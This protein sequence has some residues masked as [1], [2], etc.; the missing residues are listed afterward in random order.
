LKTDVSGVNVATAGN[1]VVIQG[2]RITTSGTQTYNEAVLLNNSTHA[3][4][5]NTSNAAVLFGDSLNNATTSAEALTINAGT[6]TVTFQGAVGNSTNLA[7]GALA[8]N[9]G[10][11]T[12][13]TSTVDAASVTTD[14]AG[15]VLIKGGRITTSGAQTYS[16]A[17]TLGAH[18]ILASTGGAVNF[19]SIEDGTS[20]FD[21]HVQSATALALGDVDIGGHL[22]VTTGAGG[23][24]QLTGTRLKVGDTATFTADTGTHQ[25]AALTSTHNTFT[26]LLTLNQINSGSWADVSVTTNAPLALG[27]L[28]S[29]GSVNLQTQGALTTSTVSTSG[30]LTVNSHGA[31]VSLGA[32]VVSGDMAVQTGGGA[33]AQTG[34]FVVTGDTSVAAGTG[35]I[36]L[37]NALNNFGGSLALQGTSTSVATSGN[38]QLASVTNSGPMTL[39]APNGS[40]DLGTAFITGGDLTLQSRDNMNLGGA[41]I[42]GSL[43]MSSTTGTVSF[44]QATVTGNLTAIT[45]GH[46]VDL[47]LPM[48]VA[49]CRCKPTAAASC[50]AQCQTPRC[51]SRAPAR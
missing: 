7:M 19:V 36:T 26:G 2:G 4:T 39:R 25:V 44:G 31:A 35:T 24:S 48:W 33:M 13:F 6:G 17:M 18:T 34:Q 27:P 50:K 8:V 5:L 43:N 47:A 21:L 11:A 3:T 22:H 46:Q 23:V 16:D 37:L 30:D 45:Q 1:T 20:A 42:T 32:V 49:I 28:Q 10:A 15:T 38:L 29:A 51:K 12:T 41:N 9:S 14:A 40:I